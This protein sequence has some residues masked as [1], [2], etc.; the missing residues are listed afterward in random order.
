MNMT[1]IVAGKLLVAMFALGISSC[2]SPTSESANTNNQEIETTEPV[3]QKTSTNN[4][5]CTLVDNGFGSQGE[6]NVQAEEVVTGLEVP[7]GIAFLPNQDMLVSERPGRV[8]LVR[9]SKLVQKP[10]AT[11]NVTDSGEGGLLG[12]ATHP[13]FAEN[14]LFYV[15]YTADRNGSQVNRVER[16]Q[17]SENGLSASSDRIILDNIPV[18]VY[19]NG[20][21]IRFGADG[22]LYIGTGD[23][24]DPQSSQDVNSLAGKILRVTPDGQVPQDNPFPKNPVYISGIR[25]TQGFDWHD[26]STLWVTD[27]GPSGE[28]GRSGHDKV[29]VARA[30]DNLGWPTIYRCESGEGLITPSIVWRQAL[31]PGGAAIY[32]GNSIPEWKGSLIIPTLRSEHLQRVV[33]NPQSPQKVERH[34]VYLQGKYGR[35]R[36]AIMG[37]DGELYVTTSNCDGRGSCPSQQDKILRI[38]K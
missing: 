20:G 11:I 30:G 15:Y 19:H 8:R 1:R 33:F 24:R 31:P 4:Q 37:P 23:A 12:I 36:E 28:L 16:W 9:D 3:S 27:H 22:M 34:E 2:A 32:T 18:A 5:V 29:S 25:N 21:R 13:N 38:T 26:A 7:W 35:L 10:V 14:R 17:L 6:V